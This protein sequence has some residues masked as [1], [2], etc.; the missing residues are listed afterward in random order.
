MNYHFLSKTELFRGISHAELPSILSRLQAVEREYE[1]GAFIYQAGDPVTFM[2]LVIS[3]CVSI[4]NDDI[5]G[6][7]NVLYCVSPGQIFAEGYACVPAV[8]LM[9]NAVTLERTRVLFLDM[10]QILYAC[11]DGCNSYC[12]LIRNML[13]ISAQKNLNLSRKILHTSAKTIRGRML[14]Y[15][16]FQA[17]Q[18]GSRE[19]DI[20]LNRQQL[21][22]YL[23]VDRS[24]LS[25]ELSKMQR[26]GILQVKNNHFLIFTP[27]DQE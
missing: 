7:K 18:H 2:G 25:N 16:S 9:V 11:T 14:S 23:S 17:T 21:A 15:L 27:Q 24:A 19:F 3:G 4:E 5:W 1:T 10:D 13:S 12:K 26:D 8:P 6:N 22:D 20:P